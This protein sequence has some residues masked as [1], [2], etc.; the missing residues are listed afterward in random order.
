MKKSANMMQILFKSPSAM[1]SEVCF[2]LILQK[3][4]IFSPL[5]TP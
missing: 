3:S 2:S 5:A 4:G 1:Q